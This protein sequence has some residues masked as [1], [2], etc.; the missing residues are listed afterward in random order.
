M[1]MKKAGVATAKAC[2]LVSFTGAAF[3]ACALVTGCRQD[4]QDQPKSYPQRGSTFFADGRYVRAQVPQTVARSQGDPEDYFHTGLIDGREGDGFPLTLTPE[5]MARGQERYNVYCSPCHSRVGN[6]LGRIVERGYYAAASFHSTRL[7]TAPLGHFVQVITK[8]Y[9]AMPD[10]ATEVQPFDRWAISAYIRA[11][12]LSQN[13]EA[14]NIGSSPR[15]RKLTDIVASQGFAPDFLNALSPSVRPYAAPVNPTSGTVPAVNVP[16]PAV[17]NGGQ[18]MAA[19]AKSSPARAGTQPTANA[20]E[21]NV[22]SA[23]PSKTTGSVASAAGQLT[24]ATHSAEA[25]REIYA[26]NCALCHQATRA[27]LPP[28]IP[29]LIGIVPKVGETHI[30]EVVTNGIPMGKPPMPAFTTLSGDDFNNLITFLKTDN[31]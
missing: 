20:P 29:G 28:L 19:K 12:Q 3:I 23:A 1:M 26:R 4:M 16:A 24:A 31:H 9:G 8:G 10:Y 22:S 30:R 25:G 17:A 2:T 21:A 14:T 11:L 15:V 13:A 6:G 18:P 5:I 7:R 27:G